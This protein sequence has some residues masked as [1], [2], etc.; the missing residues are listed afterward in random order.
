MAQ[1]RHQKCAAFFLEQR[2]RA[3]CVGHLEQVVG[4]RQRIVEAAAEF[5]QRS[6]DLVAAGI[7][8]LAGTDVE[9]RAQQLEDRQPGNVHGVGGAVRLGQHRA[10]GAALSNQL[11]AQP[12]LADAWF[13]D[14]TDDPAVT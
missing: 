3:L 5:Q 11:Q 13:P 7:G 2:D 1:K 10:A 9:Q 8:V 6:A 14:D 4:K 12:R